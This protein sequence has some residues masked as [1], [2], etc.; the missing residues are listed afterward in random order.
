MEAMT[1]EEAHLWS[2]WLNSLSIRAV[3]ESLS[4][5]TEIVDCQRMRFAV[6]A[7]ALALRA[8]LV[9]GGFLWKQ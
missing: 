5:N 4:D 1:H 9:R 7:S 2:Q 6:E 8:E 3:E